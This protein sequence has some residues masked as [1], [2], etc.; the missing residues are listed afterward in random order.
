MPYSQFKQQVDAPQS[1]QTERLIPHIE[2][3]LKNALSYDYALDKTLS[4]YFRQNPSW[5][6]RERNV[7]AETVF[8][9]V[10]HQSCFEYWIKQA[11]V[12]KWRG[13]SLLGLASAQKNGVKIEIPFNLDELPIPPEIATQHSLPQWLYQGLETQWSKDCAIALTALNTSAALDLRANTLKTTRAKL[14]EQLN[15]YLAAKPAIAQIKVSA[16][17][18]ASNG[19]RSSQKFAINTLPMF[20]DGQVE[21]QDEGSQLIVELLAPKRGEIVVDFCAGAGGKT[22]AIGALMHNS[23]ILYAFDTAEK[24]LA[25]LKPRL[26]RSGLSNVHPVRISSER[27]ARV[28]RLAKK[29]QRVLVDAPCSGVGTLRRNPDLKW[30]QTPA[31]ITALQHTQTAILEAAASLVKTQGVLLYA[32]CSLLREENQDI[33]M[34]FLAQ[35]PD[36]AI[37]P[38]GPW[39]AE[40]GLISADPDFLQLTPWQHNTDGFFA[41]LLRKN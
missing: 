5:G 29:C 2:A 7:I 28:K 41:A 3:L 22:L 23:G 11:Q 40:R 17:P 13:Y 38:I 39:C 9:V 30:R 36:F 24:R 19:I 14:L 31:T 15:Q 4:H 10:R 32:T 6:I 8:S 34:T 33:V 18:F 21:V 35:H 20:T 12:E 16:T 1:P 26:A 27:D 37:E 25:K